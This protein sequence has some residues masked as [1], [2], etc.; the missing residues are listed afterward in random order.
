ML[1]Y[2][3]RMQDSKGIVK[4]GYKGE[5]ICSKPLSKQNCFSRAKRARMRWDHE[6]LHEYDAKTEV[7][8]Q[9]MMLPAQIPTSGWFGS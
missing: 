5:W 6:D 3:E 1:R 2:E 4:L 9:S 7:L 8:M